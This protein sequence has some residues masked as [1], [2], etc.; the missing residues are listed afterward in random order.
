[1]IVYNSTLLRQLGSDILKECHPVIK[2]S[3]HLQMFDLSVYH[4]RKIW[5][6]DLSKKP[7]LNLCLSIT[8]SGYQPLIHFLCTLTMN[9]IVFFV[10]VQKTVQPNID[11]WW[12]LCQSQT[13]TSKAKFLYQGRPQRWMPLFVKPWDTI[14]MTWYLWQNSY[15]SWQMKN[16]LVVF[17]KL[18]VFPWKIGEKCYLAILTRSDLTH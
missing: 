14:T 10:F 2:N 5:L 17:L 3:A 15:I 4:E 1:M 18:F 16:W 12:I 7:A 9:K 8:R 11:P 6:R 13:E